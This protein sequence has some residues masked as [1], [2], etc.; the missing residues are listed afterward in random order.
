[1]GA[2]ASKPD[3]SIERKALIVRY[4]VGVDN[5]THDIRHMLMNTFHFEEANIKMLYYDVEPTV[6][7]Q[8][9]LYNGQEAPTAQR[10]RQEFTNLVADAMAGDIRL[11]YADAHGMPL[12]KCRTELAY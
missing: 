3:A 2:E 7:A 12:P 1:M 6:E 8:G 5:G 4:G 9:K 10:F 11:L